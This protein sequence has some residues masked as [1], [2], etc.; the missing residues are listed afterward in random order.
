V[1]DG[2]LDP[3]HGITPF[4]ASPAVPT[5][6]SRVPSAWTAARSPSIA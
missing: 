3:S 2:Q 5:A 1:V 6:I 4:V